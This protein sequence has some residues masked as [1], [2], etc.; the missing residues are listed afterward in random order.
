MV[1]G[2]GCGLKA[3]PEEL[4]CNANG[5]QQQEE[6]FMQALSEMLCLQGMNTL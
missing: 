4:C 3:G 2:T 6:T 1:L 5:G